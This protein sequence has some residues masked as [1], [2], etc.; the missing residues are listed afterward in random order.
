[1]PE[2][3]VLRL[4]APTGRDAGALAVQLYG[5]RLLRRC[6]ERS[7]VGVGI[8]RIGSFGFRC[9]G[10][11]AVAEGTA[12]GRRDRGRPGCDRVAAIDIDVVEV[13]GRL[14]LRDGAGDLDGAWHLALD[15]AMD[16]RL[17][18]GLGK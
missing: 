10:C 9:D 12:R 4:R 18:R 17:F 2:S 8:V 16:D 14:S 13:A 11:R 6:D 5:S 3:C 1:M 7:A 15:G